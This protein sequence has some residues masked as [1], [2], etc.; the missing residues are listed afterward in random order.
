[1]LPLSFYSNVMKTI[2]SKYNSSGFTLVE[3]LVVVAIIGILAGI[4]VPVLGRARESA[5]RKSCA[6]NL[7]Q[8]GLGLNIYATDNSENFPTGSSGQGARSSISLIY[9]TYLGTKKV[10]SCPSNATSTATLSAQS[11]YDDGSSGDTSWNSSY[12]YDDSKSAADLGQIA[13][14]SDTPTGSSSTN[15]QGEGINILFVDGHIEWGTST[16]VNNGDEELYDSDIFNGSEGAGTD[17]VILFD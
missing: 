9:P 4:L 8:L 5:K 14:M 10:F 1:M 6:S 2:R 15:H 7:K 3:L 17:S 16:F 12:G 13:I 11:T